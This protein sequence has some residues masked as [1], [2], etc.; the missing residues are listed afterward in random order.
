MQVNFIL[1]RKLRKWQRN[2]EK[3]KK[4]KVDK[5]ATENFRSAIDYI[6][7]DSIKNSE[8]VK[9]EIISQTKS[10]AVYPERHPLDKY[11]LNNDGTYRAFEKYRYRIVYRVLPT[12]IKI[13]NVR[14]IR[15]EPKEY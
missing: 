13:I 15:V 7:E 1:R 12:E 11:K 8:R 14:H 9:Q 5:A 3:S 2:G 6:S 4:G 10:L